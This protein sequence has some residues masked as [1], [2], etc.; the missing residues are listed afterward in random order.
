MC[1]IQNLGIVVL[2]HLTRMGKLNVV[3]KEGMVKIFWF[4]LL[5]CL[6][7]KIS[8]LYF[9]RAMVEQWSVHL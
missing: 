4:V 7:L 2:S 9:Q 6:R 3:V 1:K 5:L 8:L